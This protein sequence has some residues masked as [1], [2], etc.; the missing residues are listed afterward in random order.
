[1][2]PSLG[3]DSGTVRVVPYDPAWPLL[4]NAEARRIELALAPRSIVLEHTGSTSVPGLAA[5]PVLDILAGFVAESAVAPYIERL[6]SIGYIHRGERGIPGREFFRRGAPRAYHI[7]LAA[8]GSAFWREHL[9]FRDY[10]RTHPSVRDEY[11]RLK[12]ALAAQFPND[13]ESYIEAKAS[14]V[15]QVIEWANQSSE[16]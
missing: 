4:F 1:M 10:L 7:H 2:P 3:L 11:A 5:K 13:R 16:A 8:I 15:R 9:A 14:F 6:V 12:Q